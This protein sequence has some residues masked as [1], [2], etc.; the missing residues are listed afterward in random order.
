MIGFYLT[1]LTF[2]EDGNKDMINPA[3]AAAMAIRSMSTSASSSSLA[4]TN[5]YSI[6][7]SPIQPLTSS[8]S[9]NATP[10]STMTSPPPSTTP[11][12]PSLPPKE[13]LINFF[14]RGLSAEILRDIQQY[15]SQPYNFA[16]CKPVNEFMVAG[17]KD[18][19]AH[20]GSDELY[21]RS[22]LLEPRE[23][24]EERM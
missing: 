22:L 9:S 19:E 21:E 12:D 7:R 18:V 14:K 8:T 20:G 2:I 5:G 16:K 24:E 17:L 10:L 3:A 13:P 6:N 15:Q 1:A 4:S 11:V 23:R